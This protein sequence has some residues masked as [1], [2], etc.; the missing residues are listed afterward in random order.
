[1]WN[2]RPVASSVLS[3]VAAGILAFIALCVV[4]LLVVVVL[5]Q[6][7]EGQ[8]VFGVIF[9][10]ILLL[11]VSTVGAVIFGAYVGRKRYQKMKQAGAEAPRVIRAD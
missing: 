6:F 1:M 3:G 11:A 7:V 2:T 4:D 9:V 5:R 10:G 8:A